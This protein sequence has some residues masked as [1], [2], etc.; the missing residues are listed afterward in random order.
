[1]RNLLVILAGAAMLTLG[2]A[3]PAAAA[4]NDMLPAGST[5]CTDR[6][7]SSAGAYIR[8]R[9]DNAPATFTMRMSTTP[10]GQETT[11]FTQVTREVRI[12]IP[13]NEYPT[14]RV[15]VAPPAPGTYYFRNCVTASNGADYRFS[16]SVEGNGAGQSDVGPH[17]TVLGPGGRHCGDWLPGP[18]SG[19]G[20]GVARLVGTSTV[21]VAFSLTATDT[22]YAFLGAVFTRTAAT[23]DEVYASGPD[24]SSLSACVTNTSAMFA[25]VSFELSQG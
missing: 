25:T 6:V 21:P 17:E 10:G 8:G 1:M 19:L 11:I 13:G 3:G 20:N 23:V 9:A 2:L 24:I 4:N 12:Q 5:A 16:L 18:A 14:F 15:L 22:D 7:Q